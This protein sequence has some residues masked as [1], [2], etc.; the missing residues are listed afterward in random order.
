ME[1]PRR[2]FLLAVIYEL[3]DKFL[4]SRGR[5]VQWII[6]KQLLAMN[7]ILSNP[8]IN[9]IQGHSLLSAVCHLHDFVFLVLVDDGLGD[10]GL[11][12]D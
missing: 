11:G 12:Q 3:Y 9:S 6:Y 7:L 8:R 10:V 5:S 4:Y 2:I 1:L